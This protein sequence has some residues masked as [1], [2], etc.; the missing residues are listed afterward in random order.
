MEL[1]ELEEKEFVKFSKTYRNYPENLMTKASQT[2][3]IQL[4]TNKLRRKTA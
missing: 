1:V 2:A 4:E 3:K